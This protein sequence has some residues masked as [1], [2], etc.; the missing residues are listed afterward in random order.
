MS[1]PGGIVN[2][3]MTG[4]RRS[5]EDSKRLD[6]IRDSEGA[7]EGLSSQ[8]SSWVASPRQLNKRRA[9]AHVIA[10]SECEIID[11]RFVIFPFGMCR[12]LYCGKTEDIMS[13]AE[14][15]VC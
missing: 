5:N 3:R 10:R 14:R 15:V 4:A 8:A 6:F 9:F 12:H 11:E 7:E 2:D 1:A 13:I